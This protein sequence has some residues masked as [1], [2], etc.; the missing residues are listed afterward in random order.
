VAAEAPKRSIE[1][2]A[3]SKP[4]TFVPRRKPEAS[5]TRVTHGG[6]QHL[7][8]RSSCSSNKLDRRAI[9][10]T[11]TSCP[12][13]SA[14]GAAFDRRASS[15]VRCLRPIRISSGCAIADLR[16]NVSPLATWAAEL[17]ADWFSHGLA[18]EG[19]HGGAL[20]RLLIATS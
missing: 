9:E 20:L 18:A 13:R 4:C 12:R 16:G 10:T 1:T 14:A 8:K 7:D 2:F 15:V 3:P 17:F 5:T 19:H 6:R 11:R